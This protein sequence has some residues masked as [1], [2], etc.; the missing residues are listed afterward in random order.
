MEKIKRMNETMEKE[1][2]CLNN[3]LCQFLHIMSVSV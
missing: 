1:T 3:G 2:G